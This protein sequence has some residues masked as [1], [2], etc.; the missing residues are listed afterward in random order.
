VIRP[1]II[2]KQTDAGVYDYSPIRSEKINFLIPL[3]VIYRN[4]LPEGSSVFR[5]LR[6]G[7]L[8]LADIGMDKMPAPGAKLSPPL[9]DVSTKLEASDRYL[10]WDEAGRIS[11]LSPEEI[12]S[13]R[14]NVFKINDVITHEANRVGLANE[15]GKVEF[16][17]DEARRI[18]LLD[19]VGT[20]DECRFTLDG[21]PVSKE[22]LRTFYRGT[23]WHEEV[24]AAKK[25]GSG[26]KDKV[27]SSPE[28]L[29]KEVLKKISLLYKAACNEITGR[30]WFAKVPPLKEILGACL[31]D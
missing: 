13:L 23:K 10:G 2:K 4:S 18:I 7:S 20:L 26:W 3:E 27:S 11:G 12:G 6:D 16:G 21:K 25:T 30:E 28:P 17:F 24:E 15:D 1:K 29:D 19:T 31:K 5:R 14:K 22:L 9:F 8:S